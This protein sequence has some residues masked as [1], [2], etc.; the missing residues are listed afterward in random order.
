MKNI[1]NDDVLVQTT[2]GIIRE[3]S[4]TTL[5]QLLV[6]HFPGL[7]QLALQTLCL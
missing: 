2:M 6:L 5:V 1:K 7:S 4:W 3:F